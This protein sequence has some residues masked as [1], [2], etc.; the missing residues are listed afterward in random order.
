[1]KDP[2]RF[3]RKVD[4]KMAKSLFNTQRTPKDLKV[5]SKRA[6]EEDPMGAS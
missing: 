2:N 4:Y 5:A 3:K 1:L 6:M